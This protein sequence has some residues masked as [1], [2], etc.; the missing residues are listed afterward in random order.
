MK[1]NKQTTTTTFKK[2]NVEN[3]LHI[4]HTNFFKLKQNN[5]SNQKQINSDI[6]IMIN[7]KNKLKS[8]DWQ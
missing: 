3:I 8:L 4:L 5:Y 2:F 6:I 7:S 1:S